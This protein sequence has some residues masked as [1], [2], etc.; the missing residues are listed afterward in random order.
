MANIDDKRNALI[1]GA[2]D[3]EV[4]RREAPEPEHPKRQ[5]MVY[6]RGLI[7]GAVVV[8]AALIIVAVVGANNPL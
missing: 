6:V 3:P 2:G 1:S 5:R 4:G 8:A 7:L